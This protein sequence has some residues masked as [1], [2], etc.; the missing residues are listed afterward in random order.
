MMYCECTHC[1]NP[2]HH[3]SRHAPANIMTHLLAT[4][5]ALP[6]ALNRG[7]IQ[8]HVVSGVLLT[9]RDTWLTREEYSQLVYIACHAWARPGAG[10]CQEWGSSE[11]STLT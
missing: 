7:L 8:D 1:D 10:A 2:Q 11:G 6:P 9:R 5:P 4:C 3:R